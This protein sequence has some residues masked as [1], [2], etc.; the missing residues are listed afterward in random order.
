M[1][2]SKS[3]AIAGTNL[4]AKKAEEFGTSLDGKVLLRGNINDEINDFMSYY[5]RVVGSANKIVENAVKETI[6]EDA[7]EEFEIVD[8]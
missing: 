6:K 2:I 5:N 1:G 3:Q 8:N 7:V 4:L